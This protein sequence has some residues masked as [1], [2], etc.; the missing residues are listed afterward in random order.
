MN[1]RAIIFTGIMNALVFAALGLVV[2]K[3]SQR[4]LRTKAIVIGGAT[5]GFAIGAAHEAIRQEKN[6]EEEE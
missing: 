6:L 3:I 2:V 5:L 4:E 1:I